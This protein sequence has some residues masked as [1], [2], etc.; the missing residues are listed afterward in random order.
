VNHHIVGEINPTYSGKIF[1]ASNLAE[2][3]ERI[4]AGAKTDVRRAIVAAK[5]KARTIAKFRELAVSAGAITPNK[6]LALADVT[7]MSGWGT[8]REAIE[9]LVEG[10]LV[11]QT[12][13]VAE[14]VAKHKARLLKYG[15]SPESFIFDPKFEQ[16]KYFKSHA[17]K[18]AFVNALN[19]LDKD[20]DKALKHAILA[21][22]VSREMCPEDCFPFFRAVSD[23]TASTIVLADPSFVWTFRSGQVLRLEMPKK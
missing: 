5:F 21:V 14:F 20:I 13:A 2:L 11:Q 12:S 7:T 4:P 17:E 22:G 10:R 15:Y 8:T 16:G 19:A 18:Q 6:T 23:M 1:T 9:A 3:L